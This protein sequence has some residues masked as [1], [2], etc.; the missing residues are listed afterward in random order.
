MKNIFLLGV[1]CGM[2][3]L[4]CGNLA[5]QSSSFT[6]QGFLQINDAAAK[7][8]VDLRF[9]LYNAAADGVKI[10]SVNYIDDLNIVNG[11]FA[12]NLDFGADAFDGSERWLE[13]AARPGITDNSDR[14]GYET[15][16]P[17]QRLS[18]APY[19]QHSDRSTTS[20]HSDE[21][22]NAAKL[23]NMASSDFASAVH[24]HTG[25]YSLVG[26]THK[27]SDITFG[28]FPDE[29]IADDI[30]ISDKGSVDGAAIKQGVVAEKY[31]DPI[32][33]RA[34]EAQ[35]AI[36]DHA[37]IANAHHTWPLTDANIPDNITI[38]G[39]GSIS[40]NAIKSGTVEDTYIPSSIA[41]DS[42]LAYEAVVAP[43]GGNYTTIQAALA[44]GKRTIF[45]R[46]GTY[47]LDSDIEVTQSG[48]VII[49]ESRERV[50]IDCN[51]TKKHF[52]VTTSF[53]SEGSASFEKGSTTVTGTGTTWATAFT[54]PANV[55]IILPDM[56]YKVASIPN[57]TT[58]ILENPYVGTSSSTSSYLAGNVL[59]GV[60]L[61]NLTIKNYNYTAVGALYLYG[62][63]NSVIRNCAVTKSTYNGLSMINCHNIQILNSYFVNN[64]LSGV[65]VSYSRHCI[66]SGNHCLYNSTGVTILSATE[67]AI[68]NNQ[69]MGNNTYGIFLEQFASNNVVTGN[70][71]S[72]NN[73]GMILSSCRENVIN[74]NQINNNEQSGLYLSSSSEYNAIVGNSIFYNGE[75]GVYIDSVNCKYNIVGMNSLYNNSSGAGNDLGTSTQQKS[76][77]YPTF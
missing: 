4:C 60:R 66:L 55:Y 75:Y 42:E 69:C 76:T 63:I 58:M 56:W 62:S 26:H 71:C 52:M 73:R 12:A 37:G 14:N 13:I 28:A 45:V 34:T 6:Y 51:G 19:A 43:T 17:R 41:R 65:N 46:N 50:I 54:D 9:E 8:P 27:T 30:T 33:A 70:I 3:A 31:I 39:S 48:T 25:V 23:N 57:D 2:L 53:Y 20:S 67:C 40:G 77:N 59:N 61:E 44:A 49:G 15:L 18:P 29:R 7:Q 16:A 74:A 72:K 10:G 24:S 35:K 64:T 36:A 21:A 22:A 1:L 11:V 38:N 68:S 32:I 5:A 47:I